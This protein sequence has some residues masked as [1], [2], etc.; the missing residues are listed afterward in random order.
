VVVNRVG[1]MLT[2]FFT[3]AKAVRNYAD[4]I[5]CDT[6]A[7]ATFFREML[8]CGVVLPPSQFE[9]WFVS[10]CHDATATDETIVAAQ[11][12][13]AAVSASQ[14]VESENP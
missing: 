9:A 2:C 10:A 11:K 6:R 14:G 13:F 5:A 1:S 4:A 7:F 3:R 12:A 8:E